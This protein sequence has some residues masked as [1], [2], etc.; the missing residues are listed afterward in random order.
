MKYLVILLLLFSCSNINTP[1]ISTGQVVIKR[2]LIEL[3]YD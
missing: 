1:N 2:F 3:N